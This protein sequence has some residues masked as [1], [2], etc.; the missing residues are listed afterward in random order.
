MPKKGQA[1]IYLFLAIIILFLTAILYDINKQ[2]AEKKA[3]VT[4]SAGAADPRPAIQ[5]FLQACLKQTASTAVSIIGY[6]GGW[7]YPQ[8]AADSVTYDGFEIGMGGLY[9][10]DV[11]LSRKDAE[12]QISHYIRR[13]IN[14]CARGLAS[15]KSQGMAIRIGIPK[16]S[17]SIGEKEVIV[18]LDYPATIETLDR[19]YT[20]SA[21]Q[22]TVPV[23]LG[24]IIRD[25]G[26][27]MA[28]QSKDI[29]YLPTDKMSKLPYKSQIIALGRDIKVYSFVDMSSTLF[30]RPY[31]FRTAVKS[32]DN[33]APYLPD[34]GTLVSKTGGSPAIRAFDFEGDK[35]TYGSGD[36]R[37]PVDPVTGLMRIETPTVGK[38]VIPVSAIDSEGNANTKTITIEVR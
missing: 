28:E 35:V 13:H 15:M 5:Q 32:S 17:T 3:E 30:E 20:I 2:S 29:H 4:A 10:V 19:T 11:F 34:K 6:Q 27:V 22:T 38:Y 7:I 21:G 26:E 14:D 33:L 24:A 37:F 23:R 8:S 18:T 25:V 12:N 36:P 1:T 16:A 9:G 31:V